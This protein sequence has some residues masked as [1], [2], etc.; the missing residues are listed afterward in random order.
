M[1]FDTTELYLEGWMGKISGFTDA[2]VFFLISCQP[3][4]WIL[5]LLYSLYLLTILWNIEGV[6]HLAGDSQSGPY[7]QSDGN[8]LL[9]SLW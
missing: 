4:C 2:Q 7:V 8:F 9:V 1:A 6:W 5:H 3:I